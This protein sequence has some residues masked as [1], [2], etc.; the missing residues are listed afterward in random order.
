MTATP[1]VDRR[2][3]AA[4]S[5]PSSTSAPAGVPARRWSPVEIDGQRV[6]HVPGTTHPHPVTGDEHGNRGDRAHQGVRDGSGSRQRNY[7]DNQ[8]WRQPFERLQHR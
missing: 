1:P 2:P 3:L 4:W 5:P 7:H 8:P 6:E